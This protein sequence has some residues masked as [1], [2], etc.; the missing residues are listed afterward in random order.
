MG[1]T[2]IS[3]DPPHTRPLSYSGWAFKLKCRRRGFS[4]R[5]TSC[6]TD[7]T[8][9]STHPPPTVPTIEPSSRIRILA[10]S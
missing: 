5:I 3:S 8:S 10:L 1:S 4:S 6:A 2:K 9:A 7:H